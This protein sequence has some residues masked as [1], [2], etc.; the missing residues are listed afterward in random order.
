MPRDGIPGLVD[1]TVTRHLFLTGKGGG[2]KTSAA[3]ATAI[4]LAGLGRSVLLVS[5]DPA[6]NLDEVLGARI[7]TSPTRVEAVTGLSALNV[8][9][10]AAA[11]AY[12]ERVIGPYRGVLPDSAVA[13]VEEQLSGACTVEIAA[14]DEF[15]ALLTD[16]A[17]AA[18][19]DHVVFDTAPTGHTLRLLALPAAWSTFIGDGTGTSCLGPLSG[20]ATQ[21]AHY[22]SA[23]AVLTDATSTTLV[24]VARPDTAS[25]AEAQRAGA[26]LRAIGLTHQRLVVNGLFTTTDT[27]DDV[28]AALHTQARD[29]LAEMPAELAALDRTTVALRTARR[30]RRAPPR[31]RSRVRRGADRADVGSGRTAVRRRTSPPARECAPRWTAQRRPS[32]PPRRQAPRPA[33]ATAASPAG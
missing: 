24:L 7:G 2:G 6:S 3:C 16:P 10:E 26:E 15:T 28:A 21:Q 31:R 5:T 13:R 32:R 20:M 1:T 18:A 14:F 19:F 9:P 30:R 11:A 27:D 23:V 8:D 17:M 22:T 4:G 29:A 25:L 12:R 33:A